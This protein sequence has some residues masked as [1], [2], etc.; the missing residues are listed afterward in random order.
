MHDMHLRGLDLNLL[1]ALD[2]LLSEAHVTRAASRLSLS[3]SAMSHALARLRTQLG[4]P[5]LVR[6]AR[7]M[8]PTERALALREPLRD[9]LERLDRA[10]APTAPFDPAGAHRTFRIGVSD[11]EEITL[12]R[13][14]LR[15]LRNEAPGVD[16]RLRAL[17]P[18]K[19]AELLARG[20]LDLV[21]KPL[22]KSDAGDG[23]LHQRIVAHDGFV[24]VARSGNP[25]VGKRLTLKRYLAAPH[26]LVSP[27]GTARGLV[28][29][30]LAERGKVRRVAVTLPHFLVAPH[31][32]AD[33]DLLLTLAERLARELAPALK[34]ELHPLPLALNGFSVHQL[35]HAR[36]H[37][38]PAHR[39]L[40]RLLQQVAAAA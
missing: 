20:E 3:Q 14:L 32:V 11:Y 38:D 4:D 10:L 33:T 12:V 7:G 39:Y 13:P 8:Q 25:H 31:L 27:G 15:R 17:E 40:R 2:A 34:L 29:D 23:I 5:L 36:T 30:L 26:V 19:V 35:W 24:V 18:S 21:L 16:L 22:A 1:F 28:D 9:A 37:A 6:T